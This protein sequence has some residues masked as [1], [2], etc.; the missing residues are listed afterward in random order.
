ME[1]ILHQL[2]W[3]ISHY[4]PLSTRSHTSQVVQDF[5]HQQ[6]QRSMQTGGPK[7]IVHAVVCRT[8][9]I[10]IVQI[11]HRGCVCGPHLQHRHIC[12]LYLSIIMPKS[13]ML[14]SNAQRGSNTPKWQHTT[15]NPCC[16]NRHGKCLTR[17]ALFSILARVHRSIQCCGR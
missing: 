6:Y 15:F 4:H 16:L 8:H 3:Y 5:S 10:R 13:R 2:I 12:P 7:D 11:L 1:E 9:S 14:L 17:P